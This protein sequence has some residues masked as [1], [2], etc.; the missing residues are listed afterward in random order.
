MS[1]YRLD[2][3]FSRTSLSDRD[4][5][6]DAVRH[7]RWGLATGASLGVGGYLIIQALL[8]G[9]PIAESLLAGT[10]VAVAL[11]LYYAILHYATVQRESFPRAV[12][13]HQW[14]R[15]PA[16]RRTL[17]G[18]AVV[19]GLVLLGVSFAPDAQARTRC[20]YAGPP[21]NV[22]TV[23]VSGDL[24]S[25]VIK[26][27]G[28]EIT[29]NEFLARPRPCSGGTPTVLN[30]DTISVL[31]SP[32]ALSADVRLDGG[33]FAPGATPETEGAS[34]IE[35]QFSGADSI[36]SIVG[37]PRGDEFH[38]GPG[39]AHAG[40]NLNPRSAG[41]KDVDVTTRGQGTFL[42]AQGAGGNDTIIGEPGVL[43]N[44]GV[45]AEGGRGNDVLSAPPGTGGILDG[46]P[47]NDAI[48][49]GRLSDLLDGGAGNDRVAGGGGPDDIVG[50]PG[51]DRLFGGAGRDSIK[52]RDSKRDTVR[53]GPGRD[54]VTADRRDRVRGCERISRR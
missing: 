4:S 32:E 24:S 44:D 51:K 46:G 54:R 45:F 7:H 15:L 3:L 47:G 31:L 18:T 28:L 16:V 10:I 13:V 52:S 5:A 50:G 48:A 38:W 34:E 26:R 2:S 37:T 30:T 36:A 33:P 27:K 20:S 29:A 6:D 19:A 11:F 49:G 53:C 22:L 17:K 8:A 12:A 9:A 1:S 35:I 23:T 39:G 25:G 14:L 40:V 42:V 41:D 21:T 43:V